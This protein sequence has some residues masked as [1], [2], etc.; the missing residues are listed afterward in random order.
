LQVGGKLKR[1]KNG[2]KSGSQWKHLKPS[3]KTRVAMHLEAKVVKGGPRKGGGSRGPKT[4]GAGF[5]RTL[6]GQN[7]QGAGGEKVWGRGEPCRCLS[8]GG[9]AAGGG[10]PLTSRPRKSRKPATPNAQGKRGKK[11][12]RDPEPLS[13][14]AP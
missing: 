4:P 9:V 6:G 2:H 8:G 3:C 13:W 5:G 7:A 10:D 1:R 12:S 11:S 14:G